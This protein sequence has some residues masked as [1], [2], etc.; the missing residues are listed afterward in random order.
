[1]P[2]T[3][4][5]RVTIVMTARER[6]SLT[7]GVIDGIVSDTSLPHRFMY[8]DCASPAW[9]RDVL[10]TRAAEWHL[11]VVRFD[12]ALW[13]QEA[14]Q[15]IVG[16]IATE[17]VVFIDN[18]VTV[19]PG[20]LKALVA[21]ADETGA[22]IVAPLYLLG[23]GV[24]PAKIHMAGGTLVRKEVPGGIVLEE[25]HRLQDADPRHV[26][27]ERGE[28]DFAEFHCMLLRTALFRD[29]VLD[30]AIL[31]VH[32]HIDLALSVKARGFGAYVEPLARVT[33]LGLAEYMLEDLEFLR[34]R[35]A[36]PAVDASIAAFCRKWGVIDDERSFGGA[37]DFIHRHVASVDPVGPRHRSRGATPMS[38]DEHR[39]TRSGLMDL[40][41]RCGYDAG[42]LALLS[43]CYRLAHVL[44]DG[45]YRPCGRP[46]IDHL[47][48]TAS[49]LV[50]FGFRV[51]VV[52]AGLLHAAY[53]HA[54][55]RAGHGRAAVDAIS[56]SLGGAGSAI[57]ARVRSYT[58]RESAADD[59]PTIDVTT[60]TLH[61]A[62][63]AAIVAAN[64]IDL[65]LSG[66]LRYSGRMDVLDEA[67]MQEIRQVCDLLGV[68]GLY[69]TLGEA[70]DRFALA[71]G[72]LQTR[73]RASYRIAPDR[74]RM[75][76]MH[77]NVLKAAEA[78]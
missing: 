30:P 59:G 43:S 74:A 12:E 32:E 60:A 64:E 19:E 16:R 66:E 14:R 7:E 68:P 35:W 50:R 2:A 61:E 9:L 33:Y 24:R 56:V 53:T 23:D 4:Q 76:P 11:E 17:Y 28:C 44:V 63:I 73:M 65:H 40:A 20:W 57:E 77:N 67:R 18:D 26:R 41:V 27:V 37:R 3:N 69:R 49:V 5:P 29:G 38:G 13:P 36:A 71:D 72:A 45:G 70:R 6:H 52:A 46:F 31:C 21:C 58:H 1:M 75:V 34:R 48:G 25:A 39:Q 8:L 78:G 55:A 42:E 10:D 15:R 22:G 62:E 47:V 51:D 54:P